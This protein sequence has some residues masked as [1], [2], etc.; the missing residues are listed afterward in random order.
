MKSL[1]A[2]P[3][4]FF[5]LTCKVLHR[6]YISSGREILSP[7]GVNGEWLRKMPFGKCEVIASSAMGVITVK[8]AMSLAMDEA[9]RGKTKIELEVEVRGIAKIGRIRE[10]GGTGGVR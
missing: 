4:K 2:L 8:E 5:N 1:L 9:R 7:N 3:F 10:N 6:L